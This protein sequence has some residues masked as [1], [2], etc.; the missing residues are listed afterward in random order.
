M[1]H[2]AAHQLVRLDITPV[3]PNSTH[4]QATD[5]VYDFLLNSG[6]ISMASSTSAPNGP[7]SRDGGSSDVNSANPLLGSASAEAPTSME[8]DNN[9][10][11]VFGAPSSEVD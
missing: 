4:D 6:W 11:G 3:L 5:Q 1:S 2:D 7:G 8:T 10:R 9:F